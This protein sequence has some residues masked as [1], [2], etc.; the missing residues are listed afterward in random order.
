MFFEETVAFHRRVILMQRRVMLNILY[1][2]HR[3]WLSRGRLVPKY[4][5]YVLSRRVPWQRR[6]L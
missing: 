3:S 6:I 4:S 1:A 2:S 5:D